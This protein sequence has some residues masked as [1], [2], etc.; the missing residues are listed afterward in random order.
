MVKRQ[1]PFLDGIKSARPLRG[2]SGFRI[3]LATRDD[4]RWF[5]RKAAPYPEL[6]SRLRKQKEKQVSFAARTG[7]LIRAPEVL[8]DGEI[9][10]CYYFDMEYVRGPDG[11][12]FLSRAPDY[13]VRGLAD[14]LASYLESASVAEPVLASPSQS[15]FHALYRKLCEI[16]TKTGN[17]LPGQSAAQLF[18]GLER[19]L[20]LDDLKPTLCHGD[21]TLENTIIAEGRQIYVL[22]L[23]ES[24]FEH[25]WQDL[26]KLHQ[27]LAGGWYARNRLPVAQWVLDY[28]RR[29]LQETG[30]K[31]N[32]AYAELHPLLMAITFARI[33]P[34]A[35]EADDR[36]F[37]LHRIEHFAQETENDSLRVRGKL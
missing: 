17:G 24:P 25:Y 1:D 33:L 14:Q 36:A 11:I 8:Q 19:M 32:D 4:R 9:N 28:L 6:S 27:D 12:S 7:G 34:Y 35:K 37:V 21:F 22:D 2:L 16:Q 10:G 13:D 26:A 20:D 30:R 15:Y 29:R 5:V 23:L 18:A 31:L 3:F